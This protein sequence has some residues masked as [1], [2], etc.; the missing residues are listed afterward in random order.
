MLLNINEIRNAMDGILMSNSDT[1]FKS[2]AIDSRDIQGGEIFFALKGQ[3]TD[4]HL[5]IDE[6]IKKGCKGIVVSDIGLANKWKDKTGIILVKDTLKA[7]HDLAKYIR[8]KYDTMLVTVTGSMGKTTTKD[9]ATKIVSACKSVIKS[10]G[11]LNSITGLPLSLIKLMPDCQV[12][13][14]EMATNKRGEIAILTNVAKPDIAVLLNIAEVHIEYF[15]TIEEI[16]KEKL[17]L[18]ENLNKNALVVYNNDNKYLRDIN[19]QN[20]Y[21]YGIEKESDLMMKDLIEK[22]GGYEGY[23]YQGKRKYYFNFPIKGRWNLYNLLAAVSVAHLLGIEWD[24]IVKE[25]L[26]LRASKMRGEII[27]LRDGIKIIDES[28]N[29]NPQALL[30]VIKDFSNREVY[31][32]KIAILGDMLE[33]GDYSEN[34]HNSII[35]EISFMRIDIIIGVG[36]LMSQAIKKLG[37]KVERNVSF[38]IFNKSEDP[39]EFIKDLI[40]PGD[41]ILVKGSRGMRLDYI[42]E[43]LKRDN[44]I[45]E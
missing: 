36:E 8:K 4:G 23:F 28:Y 6:A 39:V 31:G 43:E 26:N 34:F 2:A 44:I 18:I 40:Q 35:E 27:N 13:I 37:E 14:L 10:E 7:L 3:R 45:K 22:E 24:I 11:N 19:W 12:G 25:V 41:V 20:K 32:R 21:S 16:A 17:S 1:I 33:L 9:Y 42:V 30:E 15:G 29:S 5:Y 38:Y